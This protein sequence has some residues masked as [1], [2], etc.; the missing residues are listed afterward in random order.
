MEVQCPMVL[1]T[2]QQGAVRCE[3]TIK[4]TTWTTQLIR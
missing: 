3:V 1:E 4:E 2:T